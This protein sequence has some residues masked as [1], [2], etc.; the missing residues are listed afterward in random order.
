M[1]ASVKDNSILA[2]QRYLERVVGSALNEGA[3]SDAIDALLLAEGAATKPDAIRAL[4]CR[5]KQLPTLGA[6]ELMAYGGRDG[7]RA[8]LGLPPAE[9]PSSDLRLTDRGAPDSQDQANVR[10][11]LTKL[12]YHFGYD[13]FACVEYV[14][15]GSFS[16]PVDDAILT[17]AWLHI[18]TAFELRPK[19]DFFLKVVSDFARQNSH[20]PV[21]DY[22]RQLPP[23]DGTRRLDTWLTDYAG[24]A[25][26]PFVRAAGAL[27]LIA[28]V[29]RVRVR[30]PGPGDPERMGRDGRRS[31]DRGRRSKV[32]RRPG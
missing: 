10:L 19:F 17:R 27:P 29:R 15:Q 22:L 21:L 6:G 24:A 28:A 2:R 32:R 1:S 14:S 16:A 4:A 18:D 9:G 23:W 3:S 25:D 7:F 11:A 31:G 5:R 8:K 13:A 12:G 26:T 20:H 30:E